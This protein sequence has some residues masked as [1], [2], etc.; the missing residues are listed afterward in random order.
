VRL[1]GAIRQVLDHLDLGPPEKPPP[2]IVAA[3]VH[4]S[5]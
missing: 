4:R 2:G 5:D 3:L 1:A